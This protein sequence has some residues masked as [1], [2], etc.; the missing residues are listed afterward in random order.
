M[1]ETKNPIYHKSYSATWLTATLEESLEEAKHLTGVH[2]LKADAKRELLTI[3]LQYSETISQC[4]QRIFKLWLYAGTP[5]DVAMLEAELAERNKQLARR[6]PPL[7]I[8]NCTSSA[9]G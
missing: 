6:T 1:R 9:T 3:T 5:T 7:S 2:R 8:G 4:Y